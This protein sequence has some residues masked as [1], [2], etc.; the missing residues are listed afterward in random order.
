MAILVGSNERE[1]PSEAEQGLKTYCRYPTVIG[2]S[3]LVLAALSAAAA[4][5]TDHDL[6]PKQSPCAMICL[7]WHRQKRARNSSAVSLSRPIAD[8]LTV[9]LRVSWGQ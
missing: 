2:R 4:E 7:L 6:W 8:M 1:R 9:K 5:A 3:S